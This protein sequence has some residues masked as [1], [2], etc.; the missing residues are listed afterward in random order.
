MRD[1]IKLA[2]VILNKMLF[3]STRID[4]PYKF[5]IILCDSYQTKHIK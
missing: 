5:N 4:E 3:I 2:H 1:Y